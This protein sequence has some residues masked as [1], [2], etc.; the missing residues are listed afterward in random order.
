MNANTKPILRRLA[1]IGITALLT[2]CG[3]LTAEPDAPVPTMPSS[4]TGD[5]VV[6]FTLTSGAFAADQLIPSIY[7]CDGENISPPL[8][9]EGLPDGTESLALIM[10]D[11]DAP[12]G[13][14]VHWVLYNIPSDVAGLSEGVPAE[15]TLQNGIRQGQNSGGRIGYAGPC[16]PSGTHRYF[17]KLYA[18]DAALTALP[19]RTQK[20]ALLEAMEG[21]ILGEVA[22]M[23]TYARQ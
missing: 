9:W 3:T 17:F 5:Q 15:E 2:G 14:W 7:T 8:A 11:P 4:Q 23:G 21:H 1:A 20:D 19:D 18:L 6:G 10:D 13:T 16:P 12:G 22:L